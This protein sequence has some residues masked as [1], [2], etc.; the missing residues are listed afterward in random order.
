MISRYSQGQSLTVPHPIEGN[1]QIVMLAP[2]VWTRYPYTRY[3][4]TDADS[5]ETLAFK[6]Y[7]D[8]T[9]YW[10]V[11]SMN[12]QIDHPDDLEPADIVQIPTGLHWS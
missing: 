10:F 6:A 1:V 2:L 3:Q 5:F 7:G 12:P 8:A 11:A 9:A 4:A